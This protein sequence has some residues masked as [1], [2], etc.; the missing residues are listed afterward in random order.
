MRLAIK[1]VSLLGLVLATSL[2]HVN[3]I[4]HYFPDD[5][6]RVQSGLAIVALLLHAWFWWRAWRAR[7]NPAVF[8]AVALMLLCYAMV[9]GIIHARVPEF[10]V[11]YLNEPRYVA[12]YLL[13]D[14][15]LLLMLLGHP[16]RMA[17]RAA[18][19]GVA[20]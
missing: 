17:H 18:K 4:L 19:T 3:P 12:M 11:A 1:P 8:H 5:V 7:W 15:A 13:A 9:A 14:V 6:R 16:L 2:A 10:G 20:L